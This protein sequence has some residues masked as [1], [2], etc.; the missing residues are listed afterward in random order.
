MSQYGPA[1]EHRLAQL[2]QALVIDINSVR[3]TLRKC[4]ASHTQPSSQSRLGIDRLHRRS[5]KFAGQPGTVVA[6]QIDYHVEIALVQPQ[7]QP[8]II[9]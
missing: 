4:F 7:E 3:P 1:A 2:F 6:M 9:T 5:D 8:H